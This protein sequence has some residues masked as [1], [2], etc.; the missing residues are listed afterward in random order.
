MRSR[1]DRDPTL[2]AVAALLA[3][4]LAWGL[5]LW[6]LSLLGDIP[7]RRSAGGTFLGLEVGILWLVVSTL[8]AALAATGLLVSFRSWR[9]GS[10]VGSGGDGTARFLGHLGTL[11]GG[12]FLVTILLGATAPA[13]IAC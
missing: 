2:V 7:C 6:A 5:Q 9:R 12:L 1:A 10:Q 11:A 8:A 3:S 4:P 13:F